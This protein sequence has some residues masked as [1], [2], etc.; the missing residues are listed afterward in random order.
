MGSPQ[1]TSLVAVDTPVP[2]FAAGE[3]VQLKVDQHRPVFYVVDNFQRQRVQGLFNGTYFL[4]SIDTDKGSVDQG[5]GIFAKP[6]ALLPVPT[7]Q[8]P[9]QKPLRG[10][11]CKAME[12]TEAAFCSSSTNVVGEGWCELPTETYYKQ[13]LDCY[14]VRE[15]LRHFDYQLTRDENHAPTA[16]SLPNNRRPITVGQL[17][18]I[19]TR[20]KLAGFLVPTN[21]IRALEVYRD[22]PPLQEIPENDPLFFYY[23][24]SQY[25][26]SY[27]QRRFQKEGELQVEIQMA[28]YKGD[29]SEAILTRRE[30]AALRPA[31]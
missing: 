29:V 16:L 11:D 19:V 1:S 22:Y 24:Q 27:T 4:R 30:L 7:Q 8:L 26:N 2:Y 3:V 21:I 18:Y 12:T 13:G 23:S 10:Q 5:I 17:E 15:L 28:E 6:E 9:L 20:A 25:G 31:P 14:D